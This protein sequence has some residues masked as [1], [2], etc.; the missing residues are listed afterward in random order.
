MHGV[1]I[2]VLEFH[3]ANA[4]MVARK[5]K[6]HLSTNPS[7]LTNK[8]ID[9]FR[10]LLGSQNKSE[11]FIFLKKVPFSQKTQEASYFI[12]ELIVQKN[13]KKNHVLGENLIM[14]APKYIVRKMLTS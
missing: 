6:R 2:Q 3:C 7:H 1:V 14:P 13:D 4:S 8:G 12:T 9:S 10:W 11:T 5:L